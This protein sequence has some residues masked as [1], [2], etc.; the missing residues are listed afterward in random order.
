VVEHEVQ[1]VLAVPPYHRD[2]RLEVRVPVRLDPVVVLPPLGDPVEHV[3][4]REQLGQRRRGTLD[5]GLVTAEVDVTVDREPY[6][7]KD[8]PFVEDLL[9]GEPDRVGE[10]EP[11][12]QPA[13][14]IAF[15]VLE[16]DARDPL[17]PNLG[18]WAVRDDGAVLLGEAALVVPA[19]G[20]PRP[21]LLRRAT[22]G[23][24]ADVEGVPIPVARRHTAQ[25]GGEL[26]PA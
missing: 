24:E 3:V 14:P 6:P 13:L 17:P 5:P 23:V 8:V 25:R 16:R 7:R 11:V 18:Q 9:A 4:G 22:A 26:F 1:G 10:G 19:V 2:A 12:S 15:P 20:H 21:D